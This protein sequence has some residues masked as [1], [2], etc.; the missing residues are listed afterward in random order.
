MEATSADSDLYDRATDPQNHRVMKLESRP[1]SIID[2]IGNT[3]LIALGRL[4]RATGLSIVAKAEFLNAGGSIKSRTALSMIREAESAGELAPGDTIV[5]VSSGNEGIALAMLAAQFGYRVCIVMP[6]DVP[7]ERK[8]LIERY[9]GEVVLVPAHAAIDA[10]LAD[11]F[12][13]AERILGPNT[14]YARQFENPANA[15]VH[16]RETGVELID[17][18]HG[19]IDAFVAGVG[20]GGTLTGVGRALKRRYPRARIFAVEPATAA[21][22]S[23]GP[24]GT[25][26][27][28]GIGEGFVPALLDRTLIDGVE[29]VSDDDAYAMAAALAREEGLLVGPT[30]GANVFAAIA[31]ARRLSPGAVVATILCDSAE[32]YLSVSGTTGMP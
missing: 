11:C 18:H 7:P 6:A 26:R 13:A 12:T 29:C 2:G 15:L 16:E 20:T 3:P 1:A 5:E 28:F 31:V 4:Q 21:V 32:R 19:P 22:L 9:G 24:I 14:Y 10:T 17:Q 25:H 30:S 8:Q 27:Q 23:G